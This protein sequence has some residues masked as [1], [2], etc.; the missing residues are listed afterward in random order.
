MEAQ[1]DML[2]KAEGRVPTKLLCT[3]VKGE[4]KYSLSLTNKYTLILMDLAKGN[5]RSCLFF[6]L[7]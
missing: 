2:M 3:T 6:L 7:T 1:S 4:S 5:A